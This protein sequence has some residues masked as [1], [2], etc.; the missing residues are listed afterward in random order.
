[1]SAAFGYGALALFLVVIYAGSAQAIYRM[2][3]PTSTNGTL[4][5]TGLC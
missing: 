4:L 1:M 2:V 3:A 5:A